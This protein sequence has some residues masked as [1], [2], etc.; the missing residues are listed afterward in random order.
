MI[1]TMNGKSL[2]VTEEKLARLREVL[3]EAFAEEVDWEK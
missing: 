2:N 3:L 1:G